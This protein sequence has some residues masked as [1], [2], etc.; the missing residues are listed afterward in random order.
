MQSSYIFKGCFGAGVTLIAFAL[1][2]NGCGK[3]DPAQAAG[4]FTVNVVAF[5]AQEQDLSQKIS[6]VGSLEANEAVEIKSEIDGT[7]DAISFN[8]G[9][10]VKKGDLLFQIDQRKLQAEYDQALA[11]LNLAQ[12]TSDRYEALVKSQAVSQQEYDQAAAALQSNKATLE[13]VKERLNDATIIAPFDGVMGQRFVS[14]GQFISKGV[15]LS[16]LISQNPMKAEFRVPERYLSEVAIG[17]KIDLRVAAY[18]DEDFSG[19]VYFIDPEI[20]EITRTALMKA[21]VPNPQGKLRRGMFANLEL[22]V[23]IKPN[24]LV[25]PETSLIVYGDNFSVYTVKQDNTVE[26]KSIKV[27]MR[28]KGIVEVT[29]GLAKDEIVV[30]EG[31]QKLG[32]GSAVNVRFQDQNNQEN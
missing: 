3:K 7:I 13:L 20:D 22:I 1:L 10:N 16:S 8:E 28:L 9:E 11:N 27:G 4:G 15:L 19:D 26:L 12:T 23:K 14:E 31:Y 29:E 2:F 18:A 21:Y 25:I 6:L 24:A 5:K 17:Q 32:P 30:T